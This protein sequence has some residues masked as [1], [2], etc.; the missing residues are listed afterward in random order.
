MAYDQIVKANL[1]H[2]GTPAH[3]WQAVPVKGM[4]QVK[5]GDQTVSMPEFDLPK[6]YN[7][8]PS[9]YR[10]NG[11]GEMC[12]E[13]CAHPIKFAYYIQN[14]SKKWT[15]LVGS[16]CVTHFEEKSGKALAK[17]QVWE[18]N[19]DLLRQ[20][21]TLKKAIWKKYTRRT[22][23]G[24]GRYEWRWVLTSAQPQVKDWQWLSK[25]TKTVEADGKWASPNGAITRWANKNGDRV[26]ELLNTYS[27]LMEAN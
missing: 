22:Y 20:A 24:Y 23:I 2:L 3:Q 8:A 4:T 15:M 7:P 5:A 16:E 11:A 14:D 19:R 27:E 6:G 9:L 1:E 18:M 12:C 10:N 25:I 13:L 17:E 26:R 21:V